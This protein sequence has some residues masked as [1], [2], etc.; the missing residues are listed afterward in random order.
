MQLR[1]KAERAESL[2]G[3]ILKARQFGFTTD[4]CIDMLDETLWTP[5]YAAAIL[6]H[7]QG[8]LDKIF[9][10]VRRAFV[11]LPE[12]LKPKTKADNTREYIFTH[13]F[14]GLPLD[15]SI[16][17]A[18]KLRSGT[19][20][21]LHVTE[22]AYIKDRQELNAGSKQAVPL[23]GRVTEETTA[24]GFNEF[25]DFYLQ[26]K[27]KV[28]PGPLDYRTYFYPWYENPEYSLPG[29][30]PEITDEDKKF[31]GKEKE[32]QEKFNLTDGQMLWRRWKINEL[33]NERGGIGL[34]GLQLFKQEY[35]STW[36]EAFQSG[37]GNVFDSEF[38][39]AYEAEKVPEKYEIHNILKENYDRLDDGQKYLTDEIIR[40]YDALFDK[41]VKI[42]R[43][44]DPKRE[45]V[46][47]VDPSDGM[48]SDFGF[49]DVW[50]KPR[51]T[52]EKLEQVAQV[53][54][55]MRPDDLGDLAIQ[56]AQ[57]YNDAFLGVE[58]N[59]LACVLH[60]SKNYDNYFSTVV[61]DEKTQ[62]RTKKIGWSTNSKTRDIM[63]DDYIKYFEEYELLIRS[64]AT[65]GQMQSFVRKENGKREHADGKH[66]DALFAAFIAIQMKN[67][68]PPRARGFTTK[69]F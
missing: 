61:M 40:K 14:D 69:A 24:N 18:L 66:D 19:V 58:N 56:I 60:V 57:F 32:L 26:E 59:M 1:H 64:A 43:L 45:Y 55:K 63:I 13:R 8:A 17:V 7:E 28:G 62:R 47:G 65:L 34:S 6:G 37:L 51:N 2:R 38:L 67:Y 48:G 12:G 52:G 50:A 23:T 30:M 39:E 54:A 10:I 41:G 25:Y 53:E 22:S 16:Y 35:P 31:Y 29:T 27:E 9:E 46:I 44:P 42:W 68:E 4:Y 20:Q 49:I 11:N 36:R 33:R 5:G 21:W 3:L 15:S